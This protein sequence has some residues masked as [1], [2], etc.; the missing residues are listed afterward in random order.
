MLKLQNGYPVSTLRNF[1][2][3]MMV[4][5]SIVS[6]SSKQPTLSSFVGLFLISSALSGSYKNKHCHNWTFS[7][8]AN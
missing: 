3:Y 8:L 2:S 6:M 5:Q 1:C 4:T 7:T